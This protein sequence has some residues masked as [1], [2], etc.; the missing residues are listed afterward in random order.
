M[1]A[2][3]STGK[4]S[5]HFAAEEREETRIQEPSHSSSSTLKLKLTLFSSVVVYWLVGSG[6]QVED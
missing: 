2:L 3:L 6:Q 1:H 4:S 5:A